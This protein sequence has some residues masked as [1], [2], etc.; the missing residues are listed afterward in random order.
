MPLSTLSGGQQWSPLALA[1]LAC[2]LAEPEY[3]EF[4]VV[5]ASVATWRDASPNKN[6]IESTQRPT[7]VPGGWGNGRPAVVFDGLANVIG[8]SVGSICSAMGGADAPFS[9]FM[10]VQL[11]T[12]ADHGLVEWDD[13]G[14]LATSQL[15]TNFGATETLR[16]NR[17][18]DAAS[19]ATVTGTTELGTSKRALFYVFPGT[20]CSTYVNGNLDLDA[21]ACNVGTLT[22]NRFRLGQTTVGQLDGSLAACVI[23]SRALNALERDQLYRWGAGAWGY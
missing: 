21:S 19:A 1:P 11:D 8:T 7:F 20:T 22:I 2:Y 18:D 9:V 16:Y 5:A 13:S 10:I 23:F 4:G 3:L 6:H 14:G 15:R 17:I 12:S